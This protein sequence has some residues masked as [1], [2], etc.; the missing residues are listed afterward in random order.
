MKI[1]YDMLVSCLYS[2]NWFS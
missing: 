2:F 1:V